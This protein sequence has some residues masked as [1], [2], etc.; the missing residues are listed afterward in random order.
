MIVQMN[1]DCLLEIFI[2]IRYSAIHI[3]CK[4]GKIRSSGNNV[5]RLCTIAILACITKFGICIGC[6][7]L[8]VPYTD[9][10]ICIPICKIT[11]VSM[12]KSCRIKTNHH[13]GLIVFFGR[14][15][16]D[17]HALQRSTRICAVISIY[18]QTQHTS[19]TICR[20]K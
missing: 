16:V 10:Y 2:L 6:R 12:R 3:R 11:S 4:L 18:L 5:S 13:I 19:G 17:S 9:I 14:H 15:V 8:P 20:S 1:I 7:S